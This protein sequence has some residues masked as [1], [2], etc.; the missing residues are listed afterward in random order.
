M[1]PFLLIQVELSLEP[2]FVH[3]VNR[4]EVQSAQKKEK[5]Q[6]SIRGL[7]T[8]PLANVL[9]VETLSENHTTRPTELA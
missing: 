4:I 7:N 1:P 9:R 5:K 3:S 2:H 6:G 8:G